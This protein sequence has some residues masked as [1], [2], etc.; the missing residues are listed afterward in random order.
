[1]RLAAAPLEE[2]IDDERERLFVCRWRG[3]QRQA[4]GARRNSA[5]TIAHKVTATSA[6]RLISKTWS[7]AVDAS[8]DV[9]NAQSCKWKSASTFSWSTNRAKHQATK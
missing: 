1:M 4:G 2:L 8:Q 7:V 6:L 3:N 5:A 9:H